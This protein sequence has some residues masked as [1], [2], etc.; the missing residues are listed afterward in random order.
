MR[1]SDVVIVGGGI[2]GSALATA[3]A[4]DGLDVVVLEASSQYEDR[5]RGESM[6]PWGVREARELGVEQTLL[7]AGAHVAPAW[8][9]Y[10]ADVATE[11]SE[12][13]PIPVSIMVPGVDGSM[14]LRHPDACN[15]LNA[16]AVAAGAEVHR[17]ISD[18]ELTTGSGSTGSGA[19]GSGASLRCTDAEGRPMDLAARLVVGADGRNSTIRRQ[20]GIPLCREPETSMIAGLLVEGL[21]DVPD[22]RDFLASQDDLFMAA[23]HQGGGRLRVYLCPGIAHKHRFSGP[24]GLDEFRRSAAFGCL[25]F[26]EALADA[27][28]AGPLATYPGDD[29]WTERPFGSGVVLVGDAAGFNNPIIGEGLSITMRDARTV[30]DVLRDGDWSPAAFAPYAEE[31]MERMRRLRH[32]AMFMSATFANDCDNRP[33]RRARFFELQENE[34]LLLGMLMGVMGGPEI[35]PPEAFDG[36]LLAAMQAA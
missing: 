12:A 21:E 9:H 36:R 13:N 7:D 29:S 10:D 32:A 3:L 6:H 22:D 35:G 2:G 8:N 33:A 18:V 19:S 26:G 24:G 28:P 34:P 31:R 30:R 23:F 20:A 5:V 16:A 4:R 14:N 11:I 25:P 27:K 17:G 1:S 15:A